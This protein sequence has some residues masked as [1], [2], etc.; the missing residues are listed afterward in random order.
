MTRGRTLVDRIEKVGPG[1]YAVPSQTPGGELHIVTDLAVLGVGEGLACDCVAA[2]MGNQCAHRAA[3]VVA[4]QNAQR[5]QLSQ[6]P[7]VGKSR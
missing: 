3:L 7:T 2:E 6:R 5:R 1:V 4:R